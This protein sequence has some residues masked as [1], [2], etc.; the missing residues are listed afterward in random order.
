MEIPKA[1]LEHRIVKIWH[2]IKYEDILKRKGRKKKNDGSWCVNLY[3]LC[4]HVIASNLGPY[5]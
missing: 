4:Y 3:D 2:L 5:V 1:F